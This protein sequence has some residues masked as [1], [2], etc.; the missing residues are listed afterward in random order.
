V[1]LASLGFEPCEPPPEESSKP[2]TIVLLDA[3]TQASLAVDYLKTWGA[4]GP[5][6]KFIVCLL[7]LSTEIVNRLIEA[8]ADDVVRG[9]V[10]SDVLSRKLIRLA[11]R[12]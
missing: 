6:P 7:G 9:P 12:L 10:T 2:G 5:R 8:G 1:G 4:G 11:R 3:G